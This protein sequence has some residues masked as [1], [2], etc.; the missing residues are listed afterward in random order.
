VVADLTARAKA[1]GYDMTKLEFPE[2][3]PPGEK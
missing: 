1:M 3:F 2:D